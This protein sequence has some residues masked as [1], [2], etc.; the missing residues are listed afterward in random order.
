MPEENNG[1]G[2][3]EPAFALPGST[4][5]RTVTVG[6]D[7]APIVETTA[8]WNTVEPRYESKHTYNPNKGTWS[9]IVW[10]DN[11]INKKD[12]KKFIDLAGAMGYPYTLID[13][14]WDR[15]IGRDGI[16]ELM[17]YGKDKGVTPL[18][19]YSSSGYWNDIEQSPIN[20]M[21]N[22]ITRKREMDWLQSIGVKGIKVDFFGGDKQETMRLYEDILSDADDHGLMVIFHGC[23]LPRGWERMYPNYV[24]SEAVLASENMVFNQHFC[25]KEA[26]NATLHPFI[27]N[28][29]GAMEY[30]GTF[31]NKRLHRTNAEGN[32]RRTS[33]AFQL[34][35]ATIYQSPAQNFALTPNN[36]EDASPHALE[37]MRSVPT[38]WD[39]TRYVAGYP[40]QYVVIAR[41]SGGKWYVAG[42]NARKEP[43]SLEL[44]LDFIQSGEAVVYSD[45]EGDAL[46]KNTVSLKNGKKSG[47]RYAVTIP[48]EKGFVIVK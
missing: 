16:I 42:I 38:K 15:T 46:L 31:L 18:L 35:L 13:N 19:W 7:L 30:G 36:L 44:N 39:E 33:D 28:T 6:A 29:V 17:E 10:Q 2:T 1:N 37:Y 14:Y 25:D 22:P 26:E 3:S 23:T 43:V 11:S 24:G 9:W 45:G 34:A 41:K 47:I 4:P 21:D 5:W 32:Y 8:P 40:G 27:R 20:I 12:I 48:S